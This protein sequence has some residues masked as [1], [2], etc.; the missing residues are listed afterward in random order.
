M[1]GLLQQIDT[2]SL[3]GT[4]EVKTTHEFF[5]E[6]NK[7]TMIIERSAFAGMGKFGSRWLGDNWSEYRYMGYSVTGVM[8]HN[9][10]G[11]PLAG[12]DICGFLGNTTPEL[13][14][15]WHVVGAFYP[16]SRNHNTLGSEAQEPYLFNTT[17]FQNTSLSY[18]SI[19]R[20]AMRT[21][22]SLM[23]YYYTELSMLHETG[24][25][26]YKPVFFE[27]PDDANAYQDQ[28]DNVMLGKALKLSVNSHVEGQLSTKFYFPAGTWCNVFNVT[29]F[30]NT[31]I[32]G[33]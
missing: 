12:A 24:G 14:A 4:Q 26:F 10:I 11:I 32:K 21:K 5:Q 23:N 22:Y 8:M 29:T 15:R 3:F 27:F 28:T 1:D 20:Q 19:M 7:R 18:T 25:A 9:I 13:C 33:P 30:A 16:F 2:H 17:Y 6:Q 31:C